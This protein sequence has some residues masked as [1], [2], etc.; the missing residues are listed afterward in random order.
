MLY[1]N[2]PTIVANTK[3]DELSNKYLRYLQ[4][5]KESTEECCPSNKLKVLTFYK[6][7]LYGLE[8]CNFNI[9]YFN[10]STMKANTKIDGSSNKYLRYLQFYNKNAFTAYICKG[11]LKEQNVKIYLK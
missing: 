9:L 3:I 6:I 4:L 11:E 1:F 5:Y 7:V 10:M 2:M 8:C